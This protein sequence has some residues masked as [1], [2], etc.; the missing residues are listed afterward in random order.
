MESATKILIVDESAAS[1]AT[2]REGL[3]RAGYANLDEATNGEDAL[4]KM[5]R[6]APDVV[7]L[8]VW[9]SKLDGIGVLRN[10]HAL[11]WGQEKEPSFILL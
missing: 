7:I 9:L 1:R 5:K 10:S 11:D 8:D 6:L 4:L 2:L 3:L